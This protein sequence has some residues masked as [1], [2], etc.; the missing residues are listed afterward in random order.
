MDGVMVGLQTATAQEVKVG[1]IYE[2]SKRVEIN[3][4]RW[5]LLE[6][7]RCEVRGKVDEFRKRLWALMLRVGVSQEDRI[8]VVA[9]G[10][11]W[12]DQTVDQLF[13]KATRIMDF[14]HSAQ[15]VWAV[16]GVRFGET[17]QKGK[18]WAAEKLSRL[19]AGEVRLVIAAVR[20]L[21]LEKQE[22]QEVRR[23]A[24]R[25]LQNHQGGMAYDKYKKE[26]LPI[27]S[28]AIEGSCKHLVTARCKQAGMRWTEKGVDAILALRCWV[29]NNRLDEL[30]PKPKLAIEWGQAA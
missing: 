5:E 25:Y 9:D 8:V 11:E 6:R 30:R 2:L 29:L 4:G 10:A 18:Q 23:E 24:V 14:Y 12:I 28:G 1:I 17:S 3:S 21:K 16:A 13:Y 26:G 15:R 20:R 19:K 22:G 27:G 7:Q